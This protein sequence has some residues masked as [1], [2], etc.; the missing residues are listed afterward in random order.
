MV[1][2]LK[3]RQ[4]SR[5]HQG[6]SVS[7]RTLLKTLH[8]AAQRRRANRRLNTSARWRATFA[9]LLRRGSSTRIDIHL[10]FRGTKRSHCR[11]L[12]DPFHNLRSKEFSSRLRNLGVE[13]K[14]AEKIL[15]LA[16]L[17]QFDT[18]QFFDIRTMGVV[19]I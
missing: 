7:S 2:A 9:A 13:V 4:V 19:V 11:L 5:L 18:D 15:S 10:C 6:V 14:R 8:P 12:C 17:S 16:I 1:Q 3:P